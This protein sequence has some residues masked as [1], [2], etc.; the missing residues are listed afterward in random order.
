MTKTDAVLA[1]FQKGEE[2][3]ANQIRARFGA[4]NPHDIVR[5]LRGKGYAIYL[6]ERTNSKGEVTQKYRLGTPSREMVALAY[7]VHGNELFSRYSERSMNSRFA[8]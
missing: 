7:A 1:A 5:V 4:G 3:T 6:N 8:A 2:L